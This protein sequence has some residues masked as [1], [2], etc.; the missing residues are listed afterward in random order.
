MLLDQSNTGM[1]IYFFLFFRKSTGKN[2]IYCVFSNVNRREMRP[3]MAVRGLLYSALIHYLPHNTLNST[4][5]FSHYTDN[6]NS[7]NPNLKRPLRM[8]V[9]I[10]NQKRQCLKVAVSPSTVAHYSNMRGTPYCMHTGM[11]L[12]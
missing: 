7:H 1:Y 10:Q 4:Q 6:N 8:Q 3:L 12:R 2:T 5:L 11:N 9:K